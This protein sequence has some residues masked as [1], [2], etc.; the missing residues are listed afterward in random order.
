MGPKKK[1]IAA[2]FSCMRWHP[3]N[4]DL[5]G[6]HFVV[7][8][9]D[10]PGM[11]SSDAEVVFW[12]IGYNFVPPR[13]P[14][15][16]YLV[17]NT[18]YKPTIKGDRITVISNHGHPSR[19]GTITATAEHTLGLIHAVHR[20]IPMM[21]ELAKWGQWDRYVAPPKKM[22]SECTLMIIGGGRVGHLVS[23]RAGPMFKH[24]VVLDKEN[25]K[26][27]A[28]LKFAPD[29]VSLHVNLDKDT[30]G[31]IGEVFLQTMPEGSY[32]INTSRGEVIQ[33]D[34]LLKALMSSH[35]K[36]AALDVLAGEFTPDFDPW[37]NP[38][39]QYSRENNNLVLTPH[40]A[41]STISSWQSTERW[42]I[43][44]VIERIS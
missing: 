7:R 39:I 14:A 15:C 34:A 6:N 31:M 40:L 16:K 27:N 11:G 5:M 3:D 8:E 41:G 36:G 20:Q 25:E 24:V 22:L 19:M 38:L 33:E 32:L 2:Y 10:K 23:E 26:K 30:E 18:S 9:R 4:I 17:M 28:M 1:P 12:P 29:F 44:D 35:L 21:H 42:V 37:A 13:Y 43:E